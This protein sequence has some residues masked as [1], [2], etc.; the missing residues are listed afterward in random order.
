[1]N[2]EWVRMDQ[3]LIF[4]E[5]EL[6]KV[7]PRVH[8]IASHVHELRV[9]YQDQGEDVKELAQS[10]KDFGA[11][12]DPL[13][14]AIAVSTAAHAAHVE[15]CS[16]DKMRDR[17]IS[18]EQHKENQNRFKRLEF[19][20]YLGIAVVAIASFFGFGQHLMSIVF[21]VSG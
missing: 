15:Q 20:Y 8:E 18:A 13:I 12:L 16:R 11:K 14:S 6:E 10:I 1:M 17:E 4:V 2:E 3:R 5:Q 9:L 7:R 21:K 19:V